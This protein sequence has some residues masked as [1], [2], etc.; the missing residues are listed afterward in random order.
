MKKR[1]H[2]IITILLLL[3]TATVD[4]QSGCFSM[5]SWTSFALGPGCTFTLSGNLNNS[6]TFIIGANAISEGSLIID[7][8]VNGSGAF[9]R[10]QHIAN[11]N[12]W[13]MI[14]SSAAD[15]IIVGSDFVPSPSGGM[16]PTNFDFY[17]FDQSQYNCWIN[18]RASGNTVNSSFETTFTPG[19]GYLIAYA[20]DYGKTMFEF[21]GTFNSGDV[22]AP[23][24]SYT[25]GADWAGWNLIGNPYTSAIDWNLADRSAFADNFAYVYNPYRAGGPGYDEIDGGASGAYLA[26]GQAFFVDV[27][28]AG[29]FTF[30][31]AMQVHNIATLLK[32]TSTREEAIILRLSSDEY[33]DETVLRGINNAQC[34]RDRN[35]A[36]KM[37]SFDAAV[38]QIWS[39]TSDSVKVAVNSYPDSDPAKAVQLGVRIPSDG[40]YSVSLQQQTG[41]FE[42]KQAVLKDLH[43]GSQTNLTQGGSYTFSATSGDSKRFI[44]IFNPN[45]G[46]NDQEANEK[47]LLY[48]HG[49]LVYIQS[50]DNTPV[51]GEVRIYNI[52]GQLAYQTKI[53]KTTRVVLCPGVKTGIYF[54]RLINKNGTVLTKEVSINE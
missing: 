10:Q 35:D 36:L 8:S 27:S 37:M 5:G 30:T 54:V 24:L 46:I 7:G 32:S 22:T 50:K 4:A 12:S 14:A 49:N 15:E 1:Y 52:T 45:M 34:T 51:S 3:C 18:I 17:S 42:D 41:V 39:Y 33:Y 25:A 21:N 26:P 38:P 31:H 13:H 48:S 28:N 23:A 40:A 16:L 6:G 19:K 53:S 2:N 43:N 44:L 20:Y 47:T 11:D 9:I 29:N